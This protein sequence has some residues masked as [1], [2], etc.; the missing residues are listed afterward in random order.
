MDAYPPKRMFE[1]MALQLVINSVIVGG[2]DIG[3]KGVGAD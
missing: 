3:G 1:K 2:S